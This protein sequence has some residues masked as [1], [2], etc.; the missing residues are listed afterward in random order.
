MHGAAFLGAQ[1]QSGVFEHLQVLHE[2]G[3]R[4]RMGLGEVAHGRRPLGQPRND[5]A[6]RGVGQRPEDLVEV[7]GICRHGYMARGCRMDRRF[8]SVSWKET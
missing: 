4:H 8:P 3:Q 6:P 2:A 7:R 5:V 1:H